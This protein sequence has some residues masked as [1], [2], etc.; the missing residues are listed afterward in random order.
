[1]FL[2]NENKGL[3]WQ[4]LS[5]NDAFNKI[6]NNSFNEV[7]TVYENLLNQISTIENMNLTEKNK[8]IISEM[9]KKLSYYKNNQSK[10]L[11]KIKKP[12]EE[13]KIQLNTE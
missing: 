13:V 6:P 7:R 1:M 12:L 3:I 4:I 11:Q 5:E 9:M 8:L 2:S 10:S